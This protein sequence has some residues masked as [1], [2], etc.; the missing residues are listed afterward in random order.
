MTSTN[1]IDTSAINAILSDLD[2]TREA[3]EDLYKQ[4]PPRARVVTAGGEYGPA[5]R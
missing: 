1:S 5:N 4:F 2:S 3:R